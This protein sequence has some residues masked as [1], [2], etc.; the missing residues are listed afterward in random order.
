MIKQ[1]PWFRVNDNRGVSRFWFGHARRD[2]LK[3][4]GRVQRVEKVLVDRE[5]GVSMNLGLKDKVAAVAAASQGLGYAVALELS[6]EGARVGICSRD[7]GNIGSAADL[8]PR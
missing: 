7:S 5:R 8:L 4:T 3:L 2:P 6:R 1:L